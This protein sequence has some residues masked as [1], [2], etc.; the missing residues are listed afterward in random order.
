M[1]YLYL[2]TFKV[3]VNLQYNTGDFFSN[4]HIILFPYIL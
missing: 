1:N 2:F 3:P 4:Y